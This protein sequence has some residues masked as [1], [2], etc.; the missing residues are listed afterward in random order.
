MTFL[1]SPFFLSCHLFFFCHPE[2]RSPEGSHSF[3]TREGDS[4][5]SL[6]M[7]KKEAQNDSIVVCHPEAQAEGSH[8][9]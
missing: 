9:D 3:E 5:L 4:S 8:S 1:L 7:T 6:R 2:G